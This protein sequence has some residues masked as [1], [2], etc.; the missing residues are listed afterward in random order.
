MIKTTGLWRHSHILMTLLGVN[1]ILSSC[2]YRLGYLDRELPGGYQQIAIPV[3]ENKTGE[4]GVEVYF[5]N[6]LRREFERS[7]VARVSDQS[8]AP[9]TLVGKVVSLGYAH[10]AFV[11]GGTGGEHTT[12]PEGA[13]LTTQYRIIINTELEVRRNSD[14]KVLWRGNFS[15]ERA[16]SAPRLGA[17]GLNSA[18]ALYNHS[19]RLHNIARLADEMMKQAHDRITENF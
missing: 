17:D 13:V 14:Q 16:Y 7:K 11:T 19:A 3:F 1:L 15:N 8:I 6:S 10:D 2:A 18:N 5:T 4:V 9:V 12:L